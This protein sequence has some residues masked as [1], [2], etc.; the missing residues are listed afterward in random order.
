MYRLQPL[1]DTL[2]H[3]L[4]SQATEYQTKMKN[5][6]AWDYITGRGISPD[7]IETSRLGYVTN[8]ETPEHTKYEGRLAIPYLN[9]HTG[10]VSDIRFRCVEPHDCKSV[11][12]HS[13]YLSTPGSVP[14]LYGVW[15]EAAD[16]I[17]VCEG[18]LDALSLLTA[19]VSAYGTPGASKWLPH[20]SRCVGAGEVV[21]LTDGDDAGR[22]HGRKVSSLLAGSRLVDAGDGLDANAVLVRDGPEGLRKLLGLV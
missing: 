4:Q 6:P 22:L 14:R 21:V 2:K 19:G 10:F 17:V 13:K 20:W 1:N 7:V 5:S 16:L 3:I 15:Q 9:R 8:P 18:E 11:D 12:G